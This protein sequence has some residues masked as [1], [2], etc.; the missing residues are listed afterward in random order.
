[1]A[2]DWLSNELTTTDSATVQAIN[3][4]SEGLLAYETK[5]GNV[6][7]AADADPGSAMANAYA[8]LAFLFVENPDAGK[9]ARPYLERAEAAASGANRREQMNIA[10]VRAW[11][12]GDVPKAIRIGN[13][14]ADAFVH[15]LPMVKTVQYHEF[16]L[17][18]AAG[19]LRVAER[20]AEANSDLSHM[21]G[22]SA[23]AYEQ[24]HLL[25]DAETAARRAIELKR[26]EP[27]A[28]HALAHVLITQGRI[29]EGV[30]FLEDVS[31]TWTDLN[32]F[33]LTH[34]WWHLCLNY[35]SKGRFDDVLKAYDRH[36][37]GIDKTYSQDQIGAVSLLLRLELVGVDVG[38]RWNDV[39]EH[40]KG[41]T[42]DFVQPFL[43]MQYLY[44]LARAKA[45]EA[46][47]MMA[48]LRGFVENAPDFVQDTW[49]NVAV[50]A[51]EG[52]LAH[53]RGNHEEVVRKLGSAI[54][55]LFE[56]GGSHAQRDL[57]EQ[58]LLDSVIRT[59]RYS[60]AQQMLEMRRGYEPCSVPNNDKLVE[61]YQNLGLPREAARAQ[62]RVTRVLGEGH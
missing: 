42:A 62:A 51:C 37:W 16:N 44:G 7:A 18:N 9:L 46:D 58:V 24:C 21:Y 59:G 47:A 4:F 41:R 43:T 13:E 56:I 48:N 3:D 8:A 2:K 30:D 29:D 23:F 31:Q 14:I 52:L 50:P 49:V 40:M 15:D 32:S 6:I 1:M 20:V 55:R 39:A 57:F 26:K 60:T 19:M 12:D 11:A 34:N 38:D 28:H 27:W 54:S 53:A 61:V 25:G 5:A 10:A 45:P 17:G 22:L 33:M 36:I 35:I